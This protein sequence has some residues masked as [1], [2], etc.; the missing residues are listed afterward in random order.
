MVQLHERS[1]PS[2]HIHA[3]LTAAGAPST[4]QS[5]HLDRTFYDAA[6]THARDIRNRYTVLDLAAASGRLAGLV[7]HL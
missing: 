5:I 1:L 7:P 2:T 6:L 4:P 3:A